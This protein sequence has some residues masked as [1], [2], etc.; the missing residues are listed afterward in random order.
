M[1]VL[2][3]H[4]NFPA[5]FRHLAIALGKDSKNQVVFATTRKEGQI[6]GVNK[7]LYQPSR[8][9][10][11]QTHHYV[12]P[13]E[14]AVLEG[15][16][17][18]RTLL[19]VKN[20]GF[21]PDVMY[22]HSGW[23]PGLFMKDLFPKAESLCFFEWFYH[24]RGSN[25]DFDP[26]D[27]INEDIEAKI[28]IRNAPILLD[29]CSCDRGLA[30]TQWQ[31]QQFPKEFRS[32][33]SVCHD[34]IDTGYFKPNPDVK[35]LLQPPAPIACPK[36]LDLSSATEIVT[37]VAR[38]MEPYR[39]FPQFIEAVEKLQKHRPHCHVV[40]VG[41][42]RVAYSKTLPD[43]QTYRKQ[44]LEKHTDLDHSRLHFTGHLPYSQ[45]LKVLQASSAHVYLTRP[46]VLS[47]SMLEA[48]STGCV[49][50]GSR[51]QPVQ[52]LI[53]DRKNGLLVDF[54]NTDKLV[55]KIVEV[56]DHPNEMKE[57]RKQA[58]KT[59]VEKYDLA[60]LL[61]QHLAWMSGIQVGKKYASKKRTPK[62]HPKAFSFEV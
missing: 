39:G 51:T 28:R 15:Q 29:L 3:L 54:F 11:A 24:A 33:L 52:E 12:R 17:A 32:K 31:Q 36:I 55:E 46:F 53:K 10:A 59:I 25:A 61:P 56:L 30:P 48:M 42:D 7:V 38:G 62:K 40:I 45:Y 34:G 1:K 18:Y 37:Y 50:I 43:G 5:Q 49:V 47:W 9:A 14:S 21:Y 41:E 13:L 22:A 20:Q 23:G 44:A 60:D 16:A 26:S 58:R 8:G 6:K 2:F 19:A 4:Q 27:P 57:I 35:L